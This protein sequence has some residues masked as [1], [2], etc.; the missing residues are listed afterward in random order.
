[1]R[2]IVNFL[3]TAAVAS[4][5]VGYADDVASSAAETSD[6]PTMSVF[7]ISPA[8]R[9]VM[10]FP[11]GKEVDAI[12]GDVIMQ[13]DHITAVIA[14]PVEGRN[15]NLTTNDVGGC[16]LDLTTTKNGSDQLAVF[17]PHGSSVK[18]R[19]WSATIGDD[20]EPLQI[21]DGWGF[22]SKASIVVSTADG[23]SSATYTLGANDKFLT[24]TTKTAEGVKLPPAEFRIDGGGKRVQQ[25]P[26]GEDDW[27]W[28]EDPYW[29]QSYGVTAASGS[30]LRISKAGR[31]AG[32]KV[33]DSSAKNTQSL[34]IAASSNRLIARSTLFP[35]EPRGFFRGAIQ[36]LGPESEAEIDL[37]VKTKRDSGDETIA[38]LRIPSRNA[39]MLPIPTGPIR[40]EASYLGVPFEP[41]VGF[42]KRDEI[43]NLRW[44]IGLGSPRSNRGDGLF[45]SAPNLHL[46][47]R[48]DAGWPVPAKI[49]FRSVDDTPKLHFGPDTAE[50]GVHN[51]LYVSDGEEEILIP[52]GVYDLVATHGPE[53]HRVVQRLEFDHAQ[54]DSRF[55]GPVAITL[56]RAFATPGWIS[57]D[58]HSHSSP[59]GDN[60]SSQRGRVLNLVCEDIDFA[61]CTEHNR[62]SS[63][64]G[65]ID[66]LGL[67]GEIASCSGMELTGSQLPINHHNVFPMVHKPFTQNGG[68]PYVA[69]N[70]DDQIERLYLWDE[71]SEKV[72]QQ[73][74]PDIGWLF[75]DRN[76]DG[77]VDEGFARGVD[78]L[79][80]IEVH[81]IESVLE[82]FPDAAEAQG[83]AAKKWNQGRFLGW[84][85]LLNQGRRLPGVVNTDA[86]Y[87][88]HGSGWLRNWIKVPNDEPSEAKLENIVAATKAGHIIMS[89]GPMIE[90]DLETADK[91]KAGIG[92]ELSAQ[93]GK[94]RAHIRVRCADWVH[95]DRVALLVDGRPVEVFTEAS[96][97]NGDSEIV[98]EK[99]VE[100]TLDHDAPVLAI[101]GSKTKTLGEVYGPDNAAK[102]FAAATNPIWVNVGDEKW[103]PSND[104]LDVPLAGKR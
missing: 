103:E 85:Q 52:K 39:T 47:V 72:I 20:E 80:C 82:L 18:Y 33:I 45:L 44:R 37:V 21:E 29:G 53:F 67:G 14:K 19:S 86:H 102:N 68:G 100:L 32:L 70:P 75:R 74:H 97:F 78:L 4:G 63:Y 38:S 22:I 9:Q 15:A 3:I 98:F 13:N 26:Q 50:S 35:D 84:L 24:V 49:E 48:D 83:Q 94:V 95:C 5:T 41:Y 55:T 11:A 34:R 56:R 104:D 88:Y 25:A 28:A 64:Q 12:D 17:R 43:I 2:G 87:N 30:E 90:L 51:L 66:D 57:T 10:P 71:R 27:Y 42:V 62:I 81:P 58:Y 1:M 99:T 59:S 23:K 54:S 92:D 79:D 61:P 76:G 91:T 69:D 77:E 16:L 73:D 6:R 7:V 31:A 89:N 101:C 65:H 93:D 96:D 40:V 8:T 46:Q 36:F 60:I